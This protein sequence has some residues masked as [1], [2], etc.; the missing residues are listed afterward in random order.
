MYNVH[1]HVTSEHISFATSLTVHTVYMF[2]VQCCSQYIAVDSIGYTQ[3]I[4]PS[5]S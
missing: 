2:A 1:G 3:V 5:P 4:V